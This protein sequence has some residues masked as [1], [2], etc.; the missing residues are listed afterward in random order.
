MVLWLPRNSKMRFRHVAM[1]VLLAPTDA[2]MAR[3]A[4][5][6]GT[7]SVRMPS[8]PVIVMAQWTQDDLQAN[9]LPLPA[10]V[11]ELISEDTSKENVE[12]LWAALRSCF[13]VEEEAIAAAVRSPSTILP[14]LNA[15]RNIY[16]CYD[17]L[18]EELGVD[19]AREVCSKNPGVLAC[20]PRA[21]RKSSGE[22]IVSAANT[23]D[24]I[25]NIPIPLVLRNSLDKIVF[26]VGFALVAKRVLIDCAGQSCG[27]T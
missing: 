25:E 11:E 27:G 8:P 17:Y 23:V 14:Y 1:I 22:S 16:G 24:F 6:R 10:D 12:I 20:D 4:P 2:W 7:H 19:V 15:P 26:L 18:V 9:S 21:L 5:L 3:S 13:D